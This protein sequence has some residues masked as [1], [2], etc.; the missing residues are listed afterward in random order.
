[1]SVAERA[2]ST[3]LSIKF[4]VLFFISIEIKCCRGSSISVRKTTEADDGESPE[5]SG[6]LGWKLSF[7]IESEVGEAI[8]FQ[9]ITTDDG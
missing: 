6:F 8:L 3:L 4:L 5:V 9:K 7:R 1:M 2:A